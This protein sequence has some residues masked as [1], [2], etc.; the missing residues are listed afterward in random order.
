M[1]AKT[2]KIVLI[3]PSQVKQIK[4]NMKKEIHSSSHVEYNREKNSGNTTHNMILK[5]TKT[6]NNTI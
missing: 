6:I 2:R 3:N 5:Q 4:L 1:K